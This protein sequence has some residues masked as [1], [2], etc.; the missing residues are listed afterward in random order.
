MGENIEK[1]IIYLMLFK[2]KWLLK[3]LF[4]T[5]RWCCSCI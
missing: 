4:K 5:I 1:A 2:W 3:C